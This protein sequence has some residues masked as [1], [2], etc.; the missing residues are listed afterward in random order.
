MLFP[1]VYVYFKGFC[2]L[3]FCV[4]FF[5]VSSFLDL[6]QSLSMIAHQSVLMVVEILSPVSVTVVYGSQWLYAVCL[7][8]EALPKVTVLYLDYLKWRS[9][10]QQEVA[11][12]LGRIRCH[13]FWVKG[14]LIK[15]LVCSLFPVTVRGPKQFKLS[16]FI[17]RVHC[18]QTLEVGHL[19]LCYRM[20]WSFC[21]LCLLHIL[22]VYMCFQGK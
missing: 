2:I 16:D 13:P 4:I 14:K 21:L 20:M 5:N 19:A 18:F 6:L 17:W 9:H 22:C 8:S 15:W 12:F 11:H 3:I 7:P 1:L 10:H